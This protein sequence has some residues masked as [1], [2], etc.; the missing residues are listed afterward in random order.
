MVKSVGKSVESL[1]FRLL[2]PLEL[3]RG[4]EVLTLPA[5]R[6]VRA[7]LGY[8]GGQPPVTRSQICELLWDVPNDPARR[9]AL[10]PV[11][12]ARLVVRR[13][14][15]RHRDGSSILPISPTASWIRWASPAPNTASE[16]RYRAAASLAK[17]F[18]GEM[19]EGWEARAAPCRRWITE[20]AALPRHPDVLLE[21]FRATEHERGALYTNGCGYHRSTAR[22][23]RSAHLAGAQR[24]RG[25]G[26]GAP[27][28]RKQLFSRRL[29]SAPLR[30]MWRSARAKA[31]ALAQR[32]PI[33][34]MR[35]TRTGQC[36]PHRNQ[37]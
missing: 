4:D 8:L 17:Y 1:R 2:G 30:E 19:L 35:R 6:K 29:E 27:H 3:S 25:R 34:T 23:T 13:G 7:L 26:R 28:Q 15:A 36:Q 9:T 24:A 32:T 20:S 11:Q 10:V 31:A 33:D 22:R 37:A 14:A 5:A 21:I 18:G 12:T 16:V